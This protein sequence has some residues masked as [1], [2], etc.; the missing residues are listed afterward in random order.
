[1]PGSLTAK[2]DGADRRARRRPRVL[3]A[4]GRPELACHEAHLHHGQIVQRPPLTDH[5]WIGRITILRLQWTAVLTTKIRRRVRPV[6]GHVVLAVIR[7][8]RYGAEVRHRLLKLPDRGDVLV[9]ERG[10]P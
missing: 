3:K 4:P 10:S 1:M 2:M 5:I 8:Q 6:E 7:K 9:V